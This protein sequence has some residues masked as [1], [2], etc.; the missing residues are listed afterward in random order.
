V[1]GCFRG[2]AC[3]PDSAYNHHV[4]PQR[5]RGRRPAR[6]PRDHHRH[7]PCDAAACKPATEKRSVGVQDTHR[8][9]ALPQDGRQATSRG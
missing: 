6:G 3:W 9:C 5:P 1:C 7:L 4:C 2:H 8:H